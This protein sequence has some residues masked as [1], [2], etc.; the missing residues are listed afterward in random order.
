M[1]KEEKQQQEFKRQMVLMIAIKEYQATCQHTL[2]FQG[3]I[4]LCVE[5]GAVW[6]K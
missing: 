2:K 4:I 5:C 1:E 6:V 3:N